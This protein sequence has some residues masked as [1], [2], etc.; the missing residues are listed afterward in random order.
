MHSIIAKVN[1]LSERKKVAIVRT[2]DRVRV[3]QKVREGSKE[4]VQVFEGVVIKT[5]GGRGINGSF[6]VRRIASGVGVE[7]SYPLHLPTLIKV[8]RL[9]SAKVRQAR[10]Y[11]V[12]GLVGKSAR[13]MKGEKDSIKVWEDIVA[14]KE[15]APV[16]IPQAELDA[17][18]AAEHAEEKSEKEEEMSESEAA[19][20]EKTSTAEPKPDAPTPQHSVGGTESRSESVGKK[21]E[22]GKP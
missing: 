7:K 17:I 5:A 22:D 1:K 16:E 9:K 4:R 20:Q 19:T 3:H 6:T 11:Y 10:I 14:E 8:E 13:R 15:S 2:G 21:K 18:A 12:R